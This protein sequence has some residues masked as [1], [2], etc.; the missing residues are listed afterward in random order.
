MILTVEKQTSEYHLSKETNNIHIIQMAQ[1]QHAIY[2]GYDFLGVL[3]KF[4]RNRKGFK[5]ILCSTAKR[6]IIQLWD[7]MRVN[8]RW[9]NFHFW[10]IYHFNS[11]LKYNKTKNHDNAIMI[12]LWST[13]SQTMD[14][15]VALQQRTIRTLENDQLDSLIKLTWKEKMHN[16]FHLCKYSNQD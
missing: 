4:Y 7:D 8:E 10:V 13:E 11:K 9:Q 16:D 2:F 5:Y 3:G 6:K 14:N 15:S 1:E 12:I